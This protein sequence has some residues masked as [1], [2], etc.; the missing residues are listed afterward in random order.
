M[1]SE[2]IIDSNIVRK[3]NYIEHFSKT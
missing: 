1:I 2:A 3:K